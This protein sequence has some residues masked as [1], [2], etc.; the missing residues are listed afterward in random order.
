ML[1]IA[2]NGINRHAVGLITSSHRQHIGQ[3]DSVN[4][5]QMLS[6]ATKMDLQGVS[7]WIKRV[8]RAVSE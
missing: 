1:Q 6:I 3:A 5:D 4:S 8:T 2:A 7:K